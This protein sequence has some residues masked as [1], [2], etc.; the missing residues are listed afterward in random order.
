MKHKKWILFISMFLIALFMCFGYVMGHYSTDDYHIM[1]VG[2]H[3]YSIQNNLVEGRPFMFFIDQLYLKMNFSYDFFIIST[4]VLAILFTVI[5]I[6]LLYQLIEPYFKKKNILLVSMILFSTIFHF[7]YLENLYYV[8]SIVMALSLIFYTISAKYFF[9]EGKKNFLLSLLFHVLATFCYNAFVSYFLVLITVLSLFHNKKIGKKVIF[10]ILKA[11]ILILISVFF[12]MLQMSICLKNFHLGGRRIQGTI[13]TNLLVVFYGIPLILKNT[14]YL[15]PPYV[16]LTSLIFLF[17]I[18]L[19]YQKKDLLFVE[20]VF[21]SCVCILSCFV[22]PIFTTSSFGTGRIMFG[23]GMTIGVV[24][25]NMFFHVNDKKWFY[26]VTV[27]CSVLWTLLNISNYVYQSYL[28]HQNNQLEKK[29]VL[30]LEEKI[31]NYEE[32]NGVV[33]DTISCVLESG[34]IHSSSIVRNALEAEW[35]VLGVIEFY[36]G[37]DLKQ[38]SLSEKEGKFYLEKM[39]GNYYFDQNRL[40]I[41]VYDW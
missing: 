39:D 34:H 9:Q 11:G 38:V 21:L 17:I 13:F 12:N 20:N 29:E 19:F 32:E 28:S 3:T 22:I 15:L 5:N 37:R 36:T 30:Q 33:V 6:Y 27:A 31:K 25:L 8:E 35:S 7:M 41:K 23:I 16:F 2:Y 14:C 4:V 10:D 24:L 1:N 26:Q 40:I 18:S